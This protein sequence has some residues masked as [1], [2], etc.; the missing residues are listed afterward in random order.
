MAGRRKLPDNMLKN[1]RPKKT[2][3]KNK[4]RPVEQRGITYKEPAMIKSFWK[5]YTMDQVQAMSDDEIL[6]AVDK[7]IDDLVNRS[8]K[9]NR[10]WDFPIKPEY[11]RIAS[12]PKK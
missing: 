6:Q 9:L 3:R 7:F 10:G 5:E 11:Y 8:L 4:T 1:P 2:G 12:L